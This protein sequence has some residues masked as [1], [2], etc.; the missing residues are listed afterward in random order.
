M[1]EIYIGN[2][3]GPKGDQGAVFVPAIDADNNLTWTNDGGL[4]NPPAV[5]V[6]GEKGDPPQ[7][8][9]RYDEATG[10]LYYEIEGYID[11]NAVGW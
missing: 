8:T 6:K 2:I 7:I 4:P 3:K 9:F 11:G 10:L 5:N 1:A